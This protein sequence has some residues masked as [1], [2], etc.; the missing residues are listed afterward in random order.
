[1]PFSWR[2]GLENPGSTQERDFLKAL[3]PRHR[4]FYM[5][6]RHL[7]RRNGAAPFSYFTTSRFR[8]RSILAEPP[9]PGAGPVQGAD[10]I[11]PPAYH[12][13]PPPA[14]PAPT[15][16]WTKSGKSGSDADS[17]LHDRGPGGSAPGANKKTRPPARG[18][19]RPPATRNSP[20]LTTP[21]TW[22]FGPRNAQAG[23]DSF[24]FRKILHTER[25]F[26]VR[27]REIATM[28]V[29]RRR[30]TPHR[31]PKRSASSART[32][33]ATQAATPPPW[34]SDLDGRPFAPW[35]AARFNG[36]SSS[37]TQKTKPPQNR[38]LTPPAAGLVVSKKKS[39]MYTSTALMTVSRRNSNRGRRPGPASAKLVSAN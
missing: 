15:W 8:E 35:S 34:W 37:T 21:P 32:I 24:F 27:H 17:R 1:M 23:P 20:N 39:P 14:L 29:Q 33:H 31:E 28:N 5:G 30:K 9:M 3:I 22:S 4:R 18:V 6:G 7:R 26:V 16:C 11:R 19:S 13:C 12:P 10:Q 25:V 2:S 36:A 38:R